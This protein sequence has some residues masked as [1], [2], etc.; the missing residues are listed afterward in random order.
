MTAQYKYRIE[1]CLHN[2]AVTCRQVGEIRL[3]LAT[4]P[5]GSLID[6]IDSSGLH[7]IIQDRGDALLPCPAG[8]S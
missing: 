2:A 6:I 8:N 7:H 5:G 1:Y 3:Q 4:H